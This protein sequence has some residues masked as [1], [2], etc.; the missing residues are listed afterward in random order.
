MGTDEE[1][2]LARKLNLTAL[3]NPDE[4]ADFEEVDFTKAPLDGIN[5]S[6][7]EFPTKPRHQN[8]NIRPCAD[9]TCTKFG[10]NARFTGAT[11]GD[12]TLFVS[13][14]FGE[15]ARFIGAVFDARAEFT[16]ATFGIETQFRGA[17]FSDWADFNGATF[18]AFAQFSG[19]TFGN[20]AEFI[21]ATFGDG[22]ELDGTKFGHGPEFI[23]ATFGDWFLFDGATFGDRAEFNG[24]SK[25]DL[26]SLLRNYIP[27]YITEADGK[28][29]WVESRLENSVPDGFHEVSFALCHFNGTA[30]FQGRTF[31][32]PTNFRGALFG[33]PPEFAG[34]TGHDFFDM[35]GAKITFS[36]THLLWGFLAPKEKEKVKYLPIWALVI[37]D[38]KALVRGIS[39]KWTTQTE[40]A[41]RLRRLRK[42]MQDIH[43]QDVARD[44]FIEERFAER[45]YLLKNRP[46]KGAVQTILLFFYWALSNCG[47]S[48]LAP[49]FWLGGLGLGFHWKIWQACQDATNTCTAF[50]QP[51]DY[52]PLASLSLGNAVPFLGT[53]GGSRRAV[54]N[55]LFEGGI[56]PSTI[57]WLSIFHSVSSVI[58]LF[59]I[60]LAL[61]NHF[62]IN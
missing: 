24:Q 60:G 26:R 58:L 21:G 36:G 33:Q 2:A 12:N 48:I 39:A 8:R 20:Q 14:T 22:A 45:G 50:G 56:V 51:F 54:I 53:L 28:K 5:F 27:K 16:G 42:I 32:G 30:S 17:T 35:S 44:L 4:T 57:E 43:A 55:K 25:E 40:V 38:F 19:T 10:D 62:K 6:G 1:A 37:E 13:A 61:R 47:R 49:L 52:P 31:K 15:N 3:P 9:F 11:F 34:T 18:G 59:L 7:F 41:T 29:A 23:G 46:L